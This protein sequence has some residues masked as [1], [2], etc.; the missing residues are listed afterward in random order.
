MCAM[1]GSPSIMNRE[2]APRRR[3]IAVTAMRPGLS[4]EPY[5]YTFNLSCP[6]DAW[7]VLGPLYEQAAQSFRLTATT[8][9]GGSI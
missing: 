5:L 6:E 2:N 4:G 9:V 8:K 3:A 1:Q 7:D